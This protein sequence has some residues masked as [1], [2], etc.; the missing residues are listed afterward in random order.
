MTAKQFETLQPFEHH[1]STA[2]NDNY[3]RTVTMQE[4]NVMNEIAKKL[5]G[6]TYNLTCAKC[7]FEMCKNLGNLYFTYKTH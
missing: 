6:R 1:F 3:V 5:T 2:V 7:V 4:A